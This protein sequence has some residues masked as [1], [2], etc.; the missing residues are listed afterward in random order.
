MVGGRR[1]GEGNGRGAGQS[2]GCGAGMGRQQRDNLRP[3]QDRGHVFVEATE[4]T[5]G[6]G[7][8][9]GA[10]CPL[11]STRHAVARSLD[12][13][14]DDPQG[15]PL[16]EDEEGPEDAMHPPLDGSDGAL[17]GRLQ[18]GTRGMCASGGAIWGRAVARGMAG[19]ARG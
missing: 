3:R 6:V 16:C 11:Q 7:T 9:W 14:Q 4:E 17:P 8:D 18:D 15:A 13:L 10:R 2:G 5:H 12:G 19:K 1:V